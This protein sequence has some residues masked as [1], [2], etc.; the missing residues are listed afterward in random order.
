M[1]ALGQGARPSALV[2][3]TVP[4]LIT[5][6]VSTTLNCETEDVS[7]HAP[8]KTQG[9]IHV[10]SPRSSKDRRLVRQADMKERWARKWP[11]PGRSPGLAGSPATRSPRRGREP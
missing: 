8:P 7:R 3:V 6:D 10:E 5:P 9:A 1:H 2:Q 4:D 11:L